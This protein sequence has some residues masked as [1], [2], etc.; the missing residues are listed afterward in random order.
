M[1]DAARAGLH[2]VYA[3]CVRLIGD[4]STG[5][6]LVDRAGTWG[7]VG[8][9]VGTGFE[10]YARIL[11]PIDVLRVDTTT[12]DQWGEHPVIAE[13]RWRWAEVAARTGRVMHPLVQWRRLTDDETRMSFEDGWQLTQTQQ[14]W[15]APDLLAALTDHLRETTR[16]PEEIIAGVWNGWGELHGPPAVLVFGS[17]PQTRE[18]QR[19]RA[20]DEHEQAIAPEIRQAV[21]TGPFLQWPGRDFLLFATSL[22][23]LGEPSWVRRAGLGWTDTF[24]GAMPQLLWPGDH[25]WAVA[26]EIDWDFTVVAGPRRLVD[27]VLADQRLEALEVPEDADLTWS[28]DTINGTG[29]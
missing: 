2:P 10:A 20:Q 7:S 17:D 26:S 18:R 24:P 22:T 4:V 14:G 19:A 11:H 6:W 25:G 1:Y 21:D 13:A 28:G 29:H 16:T 27:A 3:R 23:E 12:T 15:L 8:G 5:S 9:V